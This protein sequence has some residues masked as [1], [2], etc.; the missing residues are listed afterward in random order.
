MYAV[1]SVDSPGAWAHFVASYLIHQAGWVYLFGQVGSDPPLPEWPQPH[2]PP[3]TTG[4][5]FVYVTSPAATAAGGTDV[6]RIR[7]SANDVLF[8]FFRRGD[9]TLPVWDP[10]VGDFGDWVDIGGTEEFGASFDSTYRGTDDIVLHA[11]DRSVAVMWGELGLWAGY[12]TSSVVTPEVPV[13]ALGQGSDPFPLALV[14]LADLDDGIP[15]TNPDQIPAVCL[16]EAGDEADE[17]FVVTQW[18]APASLVTRTPIAWGSSVPVQTAVQAGLMQRD[19]SSDPYYL[20]GTLPGLFLTS[21]ATPL[22]LL[23]TLSTGDDYLVVGGG[24]AFGPL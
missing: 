9:G 13:P 23:R 20:R 12:A 3:P 4:T 5:C 14:E 7:V 17:A 16:T 6:L 22:T 11:T 24:W 15:S 18:G 19:T 8:T 10:G 21:A 2:E 1:S